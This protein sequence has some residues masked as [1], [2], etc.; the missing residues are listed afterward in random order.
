MIFAIIEMKQKSIKIDTH[1][2]LG[3]QFSSISDITRLITIDYIDCY[4]LY[5]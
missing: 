3:D 5:Q 2:F 4:R 1:N